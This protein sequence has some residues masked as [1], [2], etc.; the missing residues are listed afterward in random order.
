MSRPTTIH[1][2][3][4]YGNSGVFRLVRKDWLEEIEKGSHT[5]DIV[6]YYKSVDGV[7]NRV[8]S[9]VESADSPVCPV[10]HHS[11]YEDSTVRAQ[12]GDDEYKRYLYHCRDPDCRIWMWVEEY[13]VQ[14]Q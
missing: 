12:M 7:M 8:E 3:N 10:C 13:E 11:G 6:G 5:R 2:Q 1:V 4:H 9:I 14:E